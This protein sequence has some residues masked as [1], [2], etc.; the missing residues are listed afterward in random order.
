MPEEILIMRALS[1]LGLDAAEK[2]GNVHNYFGAE[3]KPALLDEVANL[4]ERPTP[5]RGEFSERFLQLPAE[6]H[7]MARE[8]SSASA[9]EERV[10]RGS[11]S[12][13]TVWPRRR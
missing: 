10:S 9:K 8:G 11:R 3:D 5:L 13:V 12:K 6:V 2:L 1:P 7:S 4:V